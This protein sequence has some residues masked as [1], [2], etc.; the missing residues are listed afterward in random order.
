LK[1]HERSRPPAVAPAEVGVPV[2][3]DDTLPIAAVS[4]VGA[5][6]DPDIV[7]ARHPERVAFRCH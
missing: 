3:A 7:D 2:P 4:I 5:P 1:P 6:V